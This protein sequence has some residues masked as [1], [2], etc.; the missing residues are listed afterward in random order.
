MDDEKIIPAYA[1]DVIAESNRV[2]KKRLWIA[3]FV[4]FLAFVGSNIGWLV[5]ESQ[6]E[7][8]ITETYEANTDNGGTAI[9]N[10]N[11]EVNINGNGEV[12][13]DKNTPKER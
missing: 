12:H 7:D 4:V 9:A 10:G 6:Y 2:E 5:Y 3:L 1:I 13:K 11:G 8:V